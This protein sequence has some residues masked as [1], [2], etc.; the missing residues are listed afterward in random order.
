M[1]VTSLLKSCVAFLHQS[2]LIIDVLSIFRKSI[3]MLTRHEY[4][5]T[6][7]HTTQGALRHQVKMQYLHFR[8]H[9]NY[10]LLPGRFLKNQQT[11]NT[12]R[13]QYSFISK[14]SIYHINHMY[15]Q[16]FATVMNYP[17][18]VCLMEVSTR[19][20]ICRYCVFTFLGRAGRM[21]LCHS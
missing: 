4:H 10:F 8:F 14:G 20:Y 13:D 5:K 7:I 12:S 1:P 11:I 21:S 9:A 18:V 16:Y 19:F 2:L 6:N 3:R 15:I 17:V